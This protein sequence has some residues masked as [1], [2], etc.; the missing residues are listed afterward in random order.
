MYRLAWPAR[1]SGSSFS[2]GSNCFT[3][4]SIRSIQ[5]NIV[6]TLE[7]E[8]HGLHDT[9]VQGESGDMFP[10]ILGF[11]RVLRHRK[12]VVLSCV[13]L[14]VLAGAVYYYLSPRYYQSN[15]SIH[16]VDQNK[17]QLSVIG[18]QDNTGNTMSTHRELVVSQVV[19]KNAIEQLD[20]QY[21][22]GLRDISPK[23]WIE[24][25]QRNT[26]PLLLSARQTS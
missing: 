25:V 24:S 12:Q 13:Y 17:D 6:T 19:V 16:I 15:A 14:F 4:T 5:F 8:Q 23:K 22:S 2:A 26:C 9:L 7:T 21:R 10:A 3:W 18:S 11:L 1:R 20:P